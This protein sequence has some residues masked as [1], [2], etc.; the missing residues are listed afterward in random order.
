ME[1]SPITKMKMG[2]FGIFSA[3]TPGLMTTT[4]P[5]FW[6]IESDIEVCARPTDADVAR[7]KAGESPV[8]H[9]TQ[10]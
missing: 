2:T 3:T 4:C 7:I 9:I 8:T 6:L 1:Q 5:I 10:C